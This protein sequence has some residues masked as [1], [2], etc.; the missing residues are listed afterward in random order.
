MPLVQIVAIPFLSLIEA[1][2]SFLGLIDFLRHKQGFDVIG[3]MH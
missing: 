3:K 2:S 1:W